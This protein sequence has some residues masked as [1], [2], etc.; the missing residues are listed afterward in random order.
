MSHALRFAFST[1]SVNVNWFRTFGIGIALSSSFTRT[2][3]DWSL[4]ARMC[5]YKIYIGPLLVRGAF[6]YWILPG[7]QPEY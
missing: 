1:I 4:L 2:N 6:P 7:K 3:H 5:E